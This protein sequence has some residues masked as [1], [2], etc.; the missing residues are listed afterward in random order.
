M[1][2]EREMRRQRSTDMKPNYFLATMAAIIL[3]LT[4]FAYGQQGNF[5]AEK[6]NGRWGAK[7]LVSPA[8]T[9]YAYLNAEVGNVPPPAA[10]TAPA[11]NR[12]AGTTGK[13]EIA[14]PTN[15]GEVTLKPGEYLVRHIDTG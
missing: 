4:G 1:S 9:Q 15:L 13:L 10:F 12:Y 3:G 5:N 2:N 11:I 7:P 8:Y 14:G 6:G